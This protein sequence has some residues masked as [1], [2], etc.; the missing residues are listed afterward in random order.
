MR[1]ACGLFHAEIPADI[2]QKQVKPAGPVPQVAG[3]EVPRKSS[4]LRP[5]TDLS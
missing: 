4:K 3:A 1:Y 2:A 5:H